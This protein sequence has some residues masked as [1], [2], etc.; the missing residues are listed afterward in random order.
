MIEE[1]RCICAVAKL[2]GHFCRWPF[3][4]LASDKGRNR[5]Y[6]FAGHK[7]ADGRK[8]EDWINAQPGIGRAEYNKIADCQNFQNSACWRCGTR[9]WKDDARYFR[10]VSFFHKIFLKR[11]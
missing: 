7:A 5:H 11:K 8:V 10:L 3:D 6:R 9:F 4:R 2:S 1:C